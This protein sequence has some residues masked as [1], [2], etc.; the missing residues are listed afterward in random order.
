MAFTILSIGFGKP[1]TEFDW[2]FTDR[3]G[4]S[5]KYQLSD[6]QEFYSKFIGEEF[7]NKVTICNYPNL[8]MDKYFGID[9]SYRMIGHKYRKFINLSAQKMN[10]Y[11]LKVVLSGKPLAATGLLDAIDFKIN[12]EFDEKR[13]DYESLFGMKKHFMEKKDIYFTRNWSALHA[14]LIVGVNLDGQGLPTH[15]LVESSWGQSRRYGHHLRMS[16]E[17]FEKYVFEIIVP[18]DMLFSTD[19][20]ILESGS[21][22]YNDE[23][24]MSLT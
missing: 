8:E 7:E 16:H 5:Y 11:A 20:A 22:D 1:V 10:K 18:K 15:W 9:V 12:G 14:L 24:Q 19:A 3:N 6:P 4:K 21:F 2:N 17:W 13:F 23:S